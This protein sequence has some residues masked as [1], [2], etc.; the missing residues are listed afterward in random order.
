[1]ILA[2][3]LPA[4]LVAARNASAAPDVSWGTA[5]CSKDVSSSPYPVLEVAAPTGA[6]RDF[7]GIAGP[8]RHGAAGIVGGL[9]G[10]VGRVR[11]TLSERDGDAMLQIERGGIAVPPSESALRSPLPVSLRTG[12]LAGEIVDGSRHLTVMEAS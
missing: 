5:G 2:C 11:G 7:Y 10:C 4:A 9:D 1:M 3:V 12:Q 8:G 6:A